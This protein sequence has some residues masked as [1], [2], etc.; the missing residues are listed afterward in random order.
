M[1]RS[2]QEVFNEVY[3]TIE[4]GKIVSESLQEEAFNHGIRIETVKNAVVASEE[5]VDCDD[6]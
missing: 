3:I 6:E 2:K 1:S 5:E 4:A